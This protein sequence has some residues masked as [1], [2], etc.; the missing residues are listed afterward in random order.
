[1]SCENKWLTTGWH[2]SYGWTPVLRRRKY[3]WYC[4]CCGEE[5]YSST[6][7]FRRNGEEK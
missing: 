2:I 7:P 3:H 4:E 1:M 5:R 6:T